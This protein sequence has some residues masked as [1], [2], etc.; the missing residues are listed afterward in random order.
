MSL[1]TA[2]GVFRM[3]SNNFYINTHRYVSYAVELVDMGTDL[4][5]TLV[6]R[7]WEHTG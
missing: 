5:E 6:E 1:I 7:T 4:K 2:G 3:W